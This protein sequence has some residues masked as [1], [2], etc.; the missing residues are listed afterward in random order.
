GS[1]SSIN[2]IEPLMSANSAVTV[3][4]SPSGISAVSAATRTPLGGVAG[5]PAAAREAASS[6]APQSAQNGLPTCASAPHLGQRT[7]SGAP[8]SAQ[9]R[10]P[11]RASTPH[12]GHRSFIPA[13]IYP[14]NSSS[15]DL[16]SFRS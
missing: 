10:L 8:Q 16:A 13:A 12:F 4:R 9:N 14:P 6:R 15:S 3:L 5:F 2:S 7:G 11:G 1:R